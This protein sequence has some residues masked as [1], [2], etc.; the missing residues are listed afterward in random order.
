MAVPRIGPAFAEG[1]GPGRRLVKQRFWLLVTLL[2]LFSASGCP[3]FSAAEGVQQ[4]RESLGAII[5]SANPVSS[6]D[7]GGLRHH[8]WKPA[9]RGAGLGTQPVPSEAGQSLPLVSVEI[10]AS[11]R[12]GRIC[13]CRRLRASEARLSRQ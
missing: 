13:A 12:S 2:T 9:E 6:P 3:L 7:H 10:A 11:E 4:S 1:I 5:S 8:A